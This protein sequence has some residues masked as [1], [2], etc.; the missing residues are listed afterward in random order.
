M[1]SS[2]RQRRMSSP[3]VAIPPAETS[4]IAAGS[5]SIG[6]RAWTAKGSSRA[7]EAPD[8]DIAAA[9]D[10]VA[11][12]AAQPLGDQVRR[13]ALAAAAGVEDARP[14][15]GAPSRPG[16]RPR[17]SATRP[18]GGDSRG[19]GPAL[20]RARRR[21][22][23]A[24]ARRATRGS[25]RRRSRHR[26]SD[27]RARAPPRGPEPGVDRLAE[28]RRGGDDLARILVEGRQLAVWLEARERGVEELDETFSRS[29]ASAAGGEP[30]SGSPISS[31][32]SQPIASKVRSW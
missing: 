8:A 11:R 27:R 18:P 21:A 2:R 1:P 10:H 12:V 22:A 28:Q 31:R 32:T 25:R 14:E 23:P 30:G 26:G 16:R 20:P 7:G 6:W 15:D 29:A 9:V 5:S 19:G 4:K 3:E 17:S 13:Q 24:P